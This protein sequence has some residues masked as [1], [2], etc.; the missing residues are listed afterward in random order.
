MNKTLPQV[1]MIKQQL[2]TG[3]VVDKKILDLYENTDRSAFVPFEYR[4]FAYSD[5]QIPLD[6]HQCMLTPLE[7]ALILQALQLQGHETVLEIG[8]GTGFF[9]ALL[10]QT[11]QHVI[12]VDYFPEFTNRAKKTC[13]AQGRTNIEFVTGDGC[14][15]W[16]AQAPYDVIVFT[17]AVHELGETLKLQASLGGKIFAIMDHGSVM[18]GNLYQVDHRNHW[19]RHLVF[20]TNVPILIDR[21]HHQPFVF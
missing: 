12:S 19:T 16:V 18:S 17:G 2:R 6:H 11:V 14:K 3:D 9:T 4:A 7:E 15:G 1:N 20:E 13:L 21:S 10:S 8:T 5:L